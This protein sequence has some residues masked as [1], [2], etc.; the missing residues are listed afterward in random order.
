MTRQTRWQKGQ[1][2]LEAVILLPVFVGLVGLFLTMGYLCVVKTWL[3]YTAH[4]AAVCIAK[5]VSPLTCEL[6]WQEQL[7]QIVVIAKARRTTVRKNRGK[8]I[9]K[10]E[11]LVGPF[12]LSEERSLRL[13]LAL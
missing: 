7:R 11:I 9:A 10:A 13:P 3:H 1:T 8:A 4:Q 5:D 6:Q 2:V 12:R